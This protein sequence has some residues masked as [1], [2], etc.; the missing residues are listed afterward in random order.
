MVIHTNKQLKYK[1]TNGNKNSLNNKDDDVTKAA[2]S[3]LDSVGM[4]SGAVGYKYKYFR[5]ELEYVARDALKRGSGDRKFVFHAN[6]VTLSHSTAVP[7]ALG[8]TAERKARI[9]F[10]S[11]SPSGSASIAQREMLGAGNAADS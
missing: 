1:G 3:D 2:V 10:L 4:Y 7:P 9:S 11:A 8:M 5:A 6:S